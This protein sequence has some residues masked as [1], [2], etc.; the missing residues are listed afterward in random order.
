M[1]LR[2]GFRHTSR[3]ALFYTKRC[4]SFGNVDSSP[5]ATRAVSLFKQLVELPGNSQLRL[6]RLMANGLPNHLTKQL[7]SKNESKRTRMLWKKILSTQEFSSALQT[8]QSFGYRFSRN[9]NDGP[10]RPV[11]LPTLL[12]LHIFLNRARSTKDVTT[13]L[14]ILQNHLPAAPPALQ[15][16]LIVTAIA[17]LAELRLVAM[18]RGLV[19]SLQVLPTAT[20]AHYRIALRALSLAPQSREISSLIKD[21]VDTMSER[22]YSLRKDVYDAL[23][24]PSFL[25]LDVA[26]VT[27]RRM[28]V[29]DT[30]PTPSQLYSLLRLAVLHGFRRRA[31][32]YL[33]L[34]DHT[35][36]SSLFLKSR[37]RFI[38]PKKASGWN[39]LYISAFRDTAAAFRYVQQMPIINTNIDSKALSHADLPHRTTSRSRRFGTIANREF[40][41]LISC[42]EEVSVTPEEISASSDGSEL[43][44]PSVDLASPPASPEWVAILRVAAKD[45]NLTARSLFFVFRHG[46]MRYSQTL[47]TYEIVINGLLRKHAF[48]R[49]MALWHELSRRYRSLGRTS[50]GIGV[51]ALTLGGEARKALS[52]LEE[53]QATYETRA[54]AEGVI[55]EYQIKPK[56]VNIEAIN[57]FMTA[58]RRRGRP[59]VV[60]TLWDSMNVLY[61]VSP[62][63]YTFNILL[64]TARWAS[65]YDNTLRGAFRN[66]LAEFGLGR[67][68]QIPKAAGAFATKKEYRD[69]VVSHMKT[70]LDPDT[71]HTITGKWGT[72]PATRTTLRIAVQVFIGNWPHLRHL[73]PPVRATR[74]SPDDPAS[75]PLSDMINS[76]SEQSPDEATP[77]ILLRFL[78]KE[79]P[80][81]PYPYIYPT[82]VTFRAFLDLLAASAL[83]SEI[84]VVLTWMRAL[85]VRPSKSTL[86]TALVHWM[87]I[88]GD[89][90]LIER[91]KGGPARS[92]YSILMVWMKDW[93]GEANMPGREDMSD[94]LARLAFWRHAQY[95]DREGFVMVDSEGRPMR[96]GTHRRHHPRSLL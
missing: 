83:H 11:R 80:L 77:T 27:K 37:S 63:V 45:R 39:V 8:L 69:S 59:D 89:A 90:P 4:A 88:G 46:C 56:A 74:R 7:W 10:R 18:I 5:H 68:L 81:Y 67:S 44:V 12:V 48:E 66:A 64:G 30:K 70:M 28:A 84:P 95:D 33:R 52:L 25:T 1:F 13:A 43:T 19:Q 85:G 82:D 78:P 58:L 86:A 62:D 32:Q 20:A 55:S 21:I 94:E 24:R 75:S 93:V 38:H 53:V 31:L 9:V 47:T 72:E 71:R 87:E 51:R 2:V 57:Q 92:P 91:L 60:F 76:L 40:T 3:N 16:I 36:R 23:L 26:E 41:R 14:I 17:K 34:L 79:T 15:P 96:R 65:K 29:E 73:R 35:N 22:G 42:P 49:A 6:V 50:F 54:L 61:N